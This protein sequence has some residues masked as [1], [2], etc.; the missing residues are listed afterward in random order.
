MSV[1]RLTAFAIANMIKASP[2]R[3]H[4]LL[5]LFAIANTKGGGA[6]SIELEIKAEAT[7]QQIKISDLAA[8][9]GTYPE[10]LSRAFNGERALKTTELEKASKVLGVPASELMR[11]AEE[12]DTRQGGDAA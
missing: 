9:I 7:R 5:D 12:Y 6:L 11:R 10:R 2:L 1:Y 8:L 3:R 4:S